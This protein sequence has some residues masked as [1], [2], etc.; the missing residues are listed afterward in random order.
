MKVHGKVVAMLATGVTVLG[1]SAC[2]AAGGS[3]GGSRPGLTPE[4]QKAVDAAFRGSFGAPPSDS[5]DPKPGEN[6]WLVTNSAQYVD[7]QAPGQIVDAAKQM[8]WNLTVFDGQFNP[9]TMVSG[10]RQAVADKA[11]GIIAF[12]VDCAIAKAGYQD[13]A[14]AGIP[15]VAFQSLDCNQS[16]DKDGT[17][18]DT[19]EPGLF[20]AVVTYNDPSDPAKPLSFAEFYRDIVGTYQA[21]GI[22]GG[23][24]GD[25]KIIKLR[26]TDLQTFFAVDGGFDKALD[27][28]CPDCEVVDTVDFVGSDLGPTLQDK[29]AQAL[30]RHPE[31]NAVF[32][33]YDAA[34]LNVAPAVMASGRKDD[35]FV[36]GGEGTAPVVDLV[37]ERRGVSAGMVYSFKWEAWAA[38]DAMDRLLAGEKPDG[39]GFTSGLGIQL[40]DA[41]RNAPDADAS[42]VGPVDYPSAYLKAWGVDAG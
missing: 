36:M 24:N 29:V 39:A 4:A 16:I 20:D 17:I 8:G 37:N 19:G 23:T 35:I 28:Y 25:A 15:V 41:D 26:Q 1:M 7:F 10:L 33:I 34:T 30:A 38:L 40:Y 27:T 42:F 5:P 6:I 12:G 31:A 14:D 22:I 3:S 32:G 21:L 2:G 11:D 9:D 13:V 18:T